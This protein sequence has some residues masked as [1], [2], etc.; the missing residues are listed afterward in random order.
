MKW[1]KRGL[2]LALLL[3]V[4]VAAWRFVEDHQTPVDIHY[5]VGVLRQ[6]PLWKALLGAAFVGGVLVG[7]PL[8]FWLARAR[9]EGR[10]Y[11]RNVKRLEGEVHELRNLP[12]VREEDSTGRGPD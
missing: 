7:L 1:L 10:H 3:F 4:V 12:V 6:V 5:E 9:L 8:A 11:R 2:G